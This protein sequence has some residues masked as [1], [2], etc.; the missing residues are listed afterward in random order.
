MT[1]LTPLDDV[2]FLARSP[3]RVEVLRRLHE[4]PWGRPDLHEETGISQP[5]LGRVLDS[6]EE[7]YWV[8]HQGGE[9]RLTAFGA[10]MAEA[11]DDLLETVETLHKLSEV[12]PLLPT[13]AMDFDLERLG[14]ATVLT[15]EPG[16]FFRHVRRVEARFED[17]ERIRILTENIGPQFLESLHTRLVTDADASAI[18]ESI[19]TADAVEMALGNHEL[20]GWIRELIES[21][22]ATIYRYDGAN[23]LTLAHY[24][25]TA[26]IV[27][28]DD[29]GFPAAV[30]ESSD[31]VVRDW[32]ETELDAYREAATELT[33]EDLPT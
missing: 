9:Y 28:T 12:G 3:H 27:A 6:L 25:G 5:T 16:D 1:T 7:R 21:G 24:D 29:H 17:A 31:E 2:E 10:L 11:F 8:E 30:I 32:V 23:P 13:D 15:P 14:T 26:V 22:R 20:V 18:V 19:L 33:V 4:G